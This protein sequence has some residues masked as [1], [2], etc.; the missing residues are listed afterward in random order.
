MPPEATATGSRWPATARRPASPPEVVVIG[1][2]KC[3]TTALHR[4]LDEHPDIVMSEPKE[5]NFFFGP[6]A[7]DHP[8]GDAGTEPTWHTGTWHLGVD[9]YARQFDAEAPVRGEASPGYTSP[10]HPEVAA[11][12][13]RVVPAARLVYLIRDPVERALSQYHHHHRDGA[14]ARPPERALFDPDS[15]YIARSRYYE[16]LVPFLELVPPERIAVVDHEDLL[17]HRRATLTRL[18]ACLGVDESFWSPQHERRWHVGDAGREPGEERLRAR[19]A[20]A[21]RDDTERLRAWLGRDLAHW[22]V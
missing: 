3:G 1:A 9:W 20:D 2:M 22:P 17:H 16:R 13:A 12:L 8:H 11:R 19:F 4:Y 21:V 5:L 18:Y 14:E 6:D 10:D 15:Q 7:A